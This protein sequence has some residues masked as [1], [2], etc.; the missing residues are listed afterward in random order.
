MSSLDAL[1]LEA[2]DLDFA[3]P[4]LAHR[5]EPRAESAIQVACGKTV[6]EHRRDDELLLYN[7]AQEWVR[8]Y[9]NIILQLNTW[10]TTINAAIITFVLTAYFENLHRPAGVPYPLLLPIGLSVVVVYASSKVDNWMR[11]N[12]RRIIQISD[13]LNLFDL[14]APDGTP[15][16]TEQYRRCAVTKWPQVVV[17]YI[18]SAITVLL[19]LLLFAYAYTAGSESYE[20]FWS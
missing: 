13:S 5:G 14:K 1:H 15:L 2:S 8:H 9:Q 12:L 11:S 16:L 4:A 20:M 10:V 17:W 19:C 3:A 18:V 7:C 6:S